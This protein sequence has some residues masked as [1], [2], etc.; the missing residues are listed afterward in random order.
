MAINRHT[1]HVTLSDHSAVWR[2]AADVR[3]WWLDSRCDGDVHVT[4][5]LYM[6]MYMHGLQALACTTN[7]PFLLAILLIKLLDNNFLCV[8]N[9]NEHCTNIVAWADYTNSYIVVFETRH[10]QVYMYMYPIYRL[11]SLEGSY[12]T[13]HFC[14]NF[15]MYRY[16]DFSRA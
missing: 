13:L 6:Y 4:S 2:P 5:T 16:M 12:S 9:M 15:Y 7:G 1:I 3:P 8:A 10:L 11:I 14:H